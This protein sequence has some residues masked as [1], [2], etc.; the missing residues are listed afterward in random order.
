MSAAL[1]DTDYPCPKSANVPELKYKG[2]P[3]GEKV[4]G[5]IFEKTRGD[6][7]KKDLNTDVM[8]SAIWGY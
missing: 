4:L 3:A 6:K 1:R 5:T 7:D 8:L 2:L